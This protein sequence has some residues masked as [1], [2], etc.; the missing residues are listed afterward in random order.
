MRHVKEDTTHCDSP[1]ALE[2]GE[3]VT[4]SGFPLAQIS[5]GLCAIANQFGARWRA[6]RMHHQKAKV[7]L[8]H[9]RLHA[10]KSTSLAS[11][12]VLIH[13]PP[14]SVMGEPA[15]LLFSLDN[16]LLKNLFII[17]FINRR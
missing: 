11:C 8:F 1:I 12:C 3:R 16:V 6:R 14:L 2:T 13:I 10:Y 4:G 15:I 9:F 17:S 7:G 5:T